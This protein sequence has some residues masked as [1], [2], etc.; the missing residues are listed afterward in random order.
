[1]P[2]ATS[3]PSFQDFA[4][5]AAVNKS[6]FVLLQERGIVAPG[7]FYHHFTDKTRVAK[8]LEPL[9][10]GVEIGGTTH[11]RTED[12]LLVDQATLLEMWDLIEQSRTPS[13]QSPTVAQTATTG[14]SST[15]AAEDKKLPK[16]Y[17]KD[18]I[19]DY[20]AVVVDNRPRKFP[21]HLIAGADDILARMVS[22][23]KNLSFT[24][25]QLGELL[26][27]R[28]FT[29]SH[30]VNPWSLKNRDDP[31]VKMFAKEDGTFEK[32][33]KT[34]PEP[35]RLLTMLDALDGVRWAFVFAAWGENADI[36][37]YIDW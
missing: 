7:V 32:V 8:F 21:V 27:A 33:A 31:S 34:V 22:E 16:G 2:P 17:W 23:K 11:R 26:A 37:D 6:V 35:Q 19:R 18:F 5:S 20:E 15:T 36:H 30:Q 24:P 13:T 12:E 14:S 25:V 10:A 1:M 4:T 29:P 28:H 3:S 9:R